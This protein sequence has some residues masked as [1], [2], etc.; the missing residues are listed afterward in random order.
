MKNKLLILFGLF[1]ILT[2]SFAQETKDKTEKSKK[3]SAKNE[4]VTKKQVKL[5]RKK[6][7]KNLANSPFKKTMTLSKPERKALRIPPN[8]YYEMEWELTM[9]PEKGRPTP[10]NLKQISEKLKKERAQA[11]AEGRTPGDAAN[12][13]WVERG[14]NN[15]GGRVRAIMFD[16]T[17]LSYKT[18]I[19]GSVSGGLWKNT[20][21]FST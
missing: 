18:V 4:T 3:V 21:I 13:A 6:H 7:A 14:P 9:D 2:S 20:N 15:V 8:K 5:I 1:F 16:P 11:L 17:D 12:N 10:E 19:A